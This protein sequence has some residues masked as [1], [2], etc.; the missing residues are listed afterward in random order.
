ML[1]TALQLEVAALARSP[2]AA[3]EFETPIALPSTSRPADVVISTGNA[4]VITE[5]FCIYNDQKTS[6]AMAYD[7]SFGFRLNMIAL[8]VRLSGHYDV[9]LPVAETELL[10]VRQPPFA[11]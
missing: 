3:V 1:H 7:Q 11:I 2:G 8:D 6:E 4:Q 9:R 10:L 5:C